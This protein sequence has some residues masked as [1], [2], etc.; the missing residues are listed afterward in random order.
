MITAKEIIDDVRFRLKDL[1]KRQFNDNIALR[2]VND[3]I[4]TIVEDNGGMIVTRTTLSFEGQIAY[5][6]DMD[7]KAIEQVSYDGQ[8]IE[9]MDYNEM[10]DEHVINTENVPEGTPDYYAVRMYG[11]TGTKYLFFYPVPSQAN[12]II[13]IDAKIYYPVIMTTTWTDIIGLPDEIT[14]AVRDKTTYYVAR[15]LGN[16]ELMRMW[17]FESNRTKIESRP[18]KNL[19]RH[20]MQIK[21]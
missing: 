7:I 12:K 21:I 16:M 4:K 9:K 15:E 5:G 6:L 20:G 11:T 14:D 10:I 8:V 3:A 2:C 13:R 18:T 19:Y 17:D 1:E